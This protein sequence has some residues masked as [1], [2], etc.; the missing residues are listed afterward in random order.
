MSVF[1]KFPGLDNNLRY[2][3]FGQPLVRNI[4]VN[5]L[6]GHLSKEYPSK[7]LTLSFHG[8]PGSGKNYVSDFIVKS[9]Y[10]EEHKSPNV[11]VFVAKIHFPLKHEVP[12]YQV[13][14]FILKENVLYF[15]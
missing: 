11:H 1:K 9:L 4:V 13:R 15:G 14:S 3:L 6:R 5:A 10:L 8:W 7:P 12:K 2:Y